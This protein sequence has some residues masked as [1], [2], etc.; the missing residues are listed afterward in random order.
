MVEQLE[1]LLNIDQVCE[2][3]GM[4]KAHFLKLRTEGIGPPAVRL[5]ERRIA[6]RARDVNAWSASRLEAVK[7][8]SQPEGDAAGA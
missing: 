4:S 8:K 6:F 1:P 3:L 7:P 5:G 2:G